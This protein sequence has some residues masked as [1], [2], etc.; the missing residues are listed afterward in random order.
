MNEVK[1]L[2]SGNLFLI[3]AMEWLKGRERSNV[4]M[5]RRTLSVLENSPPVPGVPGWGSAVATGQV[6]MLKH[7]PPAHVGNRWAHGRQ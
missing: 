1:E 6:S 3:A 7:A 4:A 5:H 2:R